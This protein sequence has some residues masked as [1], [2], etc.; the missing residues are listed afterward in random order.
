M[1]LVLSVFDL[2]IN[3]AAWCQNNYNF[4]YWNL[5]HKEKNQ[6]WLHLESRALFMSFKVLQFGYKAASVRSAWCWWWSKWTPPVAPPGVHWVYCSSLHQ[7]THHHVVVSLQGDML[8]LHSGFLRIIWYISVW[9][10]WLE[11]LG[12]VRGCS[13]RCWCYQHVQSDINEV[14]SIIET[15]NA[16]LWNDPSQTHKSPINGTGRRF[17]FKAFSNKTSWIC[18]LVKL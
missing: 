5:R 16:I 17:F 10:N 15:L 8:C 2:E 14:D 11:A 1:F 13:L 12:N 4:W 7:V 9:I 3:T 18:P 6:S